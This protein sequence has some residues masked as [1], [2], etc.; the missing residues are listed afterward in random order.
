VMICY[1]LFQTHG[2]VGACLCCFSFI[3]VV[4]NKNEISMIM[5]IKNN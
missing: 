3:D 1:K 2:I 4:I 5:V